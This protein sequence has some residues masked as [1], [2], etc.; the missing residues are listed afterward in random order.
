MDGHI[1]LFIGLSIATVLPVFVIMLV[2]GGAIG[3]LDVV[4]FKTHPGTTLLDFCAQALD[5]FSGI[6]TAMLGA[7]IASRF[8]A[9][10]RDQTNQSE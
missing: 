6:L 9:R 4:I 8:Y 2:I 3:G 7:A 5:D 1:W 10:F